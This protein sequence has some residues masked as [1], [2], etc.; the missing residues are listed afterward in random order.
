M[1]N[2]SDTPNVFDVKQLEFYQRKAARRTFWSRVALLLLIFGMMATNATLTQ[3][4]YEAMLINVNQARLGQLQLH[5]A[6]L[7]KLDDIDQRL[8]ALEAT[9][10]RLET[11]QIRHQAMLATR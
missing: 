2:S 11:T 1:T 8:G 7:L 10:H 6:T 3:R 9:V 5:E 4:N